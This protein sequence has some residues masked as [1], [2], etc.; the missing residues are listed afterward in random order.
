VLAGLVTRRT[1]EANLFISNGYPGNVQPV[2][3]EQDV[4]EPNNAGVG[5]LT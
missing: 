2:P 5:S 1:A 3:K 4:L